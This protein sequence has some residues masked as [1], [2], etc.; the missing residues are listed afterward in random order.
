MFSVVFCS[1]FTCSKVVLNPASTVYLVLAALP[2]FSLHAGNIKF[3]TPNEEL[4]SIPTCNN[5][6]ILPGFFS[7]HHV[8]KHLLIIIRNVY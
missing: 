7:I 6:L 2:K 1:V 8:Q 4:I 3:S 5:V